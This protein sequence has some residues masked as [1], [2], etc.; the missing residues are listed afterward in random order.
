MINN[1]SIIIP[2]YNEEKNILNTLN[3]CFK[4]LK[5]YSLNYEVI[6]VD[7]CSNDDTYTILK[8]YRENPIILLRNKK[9]IGFGG[10]YWE[11]VK[12]S[13]NDMIFILPG[14]NENNLN[15]ILK[16]HKLLKKFEIIVPYPINR[17]ST[18]F[19]KKLSYLFTKI[20]NFSF[21]TSFK[22]TNGSI[23]F[24]KKILE[25]IRFRDYSFLFMTSTLIQAISK[26]KS[27]V[28]VPYNLNENFNHQTRNSS[29]LKI[30]NVFRLFRSYVYLLYFIKIKKNYKKL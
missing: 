10:S 17:K 7:D 23:I 22:Y 25:N 12:K 24:K 21:N 18:F 8:N 14:D 11:G 29:A 27:Y 16:Y 20:I 2:A 13:T 30:R 3:E 19:R 1:I 4:T 28:E 5:N 9:N 15:E 6:C 26:G